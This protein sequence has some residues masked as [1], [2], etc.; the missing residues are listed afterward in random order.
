MS[1]L[2]KRQHYLLLDFGYC[3]VG[4]ARD[5]RFHRWGRILIVVVYC[6]RLERVMMHLLQLQ[7]H[8]GFMGEQIVN[9]FLVRLARG[10]VSFLDFILLSIS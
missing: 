6:C 3:H 8:Y 10:D 7:G 1:Y 5:Y 2:N 4:L 9:D